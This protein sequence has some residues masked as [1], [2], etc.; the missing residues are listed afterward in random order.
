MTEVC[1]L[2]CVPFWF[3]TGPGI[4]PP[5]QGRE[6]AGNEEIGAVQIHYDDDVDDDDDDDDDDQGFF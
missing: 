5:L 3:L 6:Q 2:C 4:R 1:A